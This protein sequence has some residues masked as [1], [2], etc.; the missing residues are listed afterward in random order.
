MSTTPY[1]DAIVANPLMSVANLFPL[2][3]A[4]YNCNPPSTWDNPANAKACLDAIYFLIDNR[5]NDQIDAGGFRLDYEQYESRKRTLEMRLGMLA[6]PRAGRSN[7][8][9]ASFAGRSRIG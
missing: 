3:K 5:A 8:V 4:Q 6:S 2:A 7:R 1:T 9:T